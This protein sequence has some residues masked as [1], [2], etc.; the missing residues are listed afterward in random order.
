MTFSYNKYMR[1]N[2][3]K[4]HFTKIGHKSLI[5]RLI[6]KSRF[7]ADIIIIPLANL[8]GYFSII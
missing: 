1:E 7:N 8:L 6:P 5:D 4:L 3:A 2:D